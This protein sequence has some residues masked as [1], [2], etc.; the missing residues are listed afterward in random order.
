[1]QL[2][3]GSL[4]RGIDSLLVGKL[5]R[6]DVLLIFGQSVHLPQEGSPVRMRRGVL[7]LPFDASKVRSETHHAERS[8]DRRTPHKLTSLNHTEMNREQEDPASGVGRIMP[9]SV[10]RMGICRRSI[11][12]TKNLRVQLL[13]RIASQYLLM[14][15]SLR[16]FQI[17][18]A[19][20]K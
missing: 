7:D 6:L 16:R 1:M 9:T 4:L 15:S 2:L 18:N 8:Q 5:D 10:N 12:A 19:F 17:L 3:A 20:L 14:D 11:A 13:F